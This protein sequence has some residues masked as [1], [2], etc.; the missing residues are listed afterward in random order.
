VSKKDYYE[1]LGVSRNAS[2]A[3]MKSAYRKL[4]G[5]YHPDVNKDAGSEAKFKEL[6]EA[7]SVLGDSQKKTQYDQFGH[8]GM[9]GY[10]SGGGGFGGFDMSG[11]SD[12][13]GD[14]FENFFSG[15]SR[16]RGRQG[17]P[18]P[19]NDLRYDLTITL[20]EAFHGVDKEI[21]ILHLISCSTCKGSGAKA[22]TKSTT[23][24]TCGG[25]GMVR[26]EQRTILGNFATTTTCPSCAGQGTIV[27]S[28][29]SQCQGHGVE[30]KQERVKVNIP[31]GVDNGSRLRVSG[32]GDAGLKGGHSGDLYIYLSVATHA[33]F[34][35]QRDDLFSTSHISFV[36]ATLGTEIEVP[37]IDGKIKLKIP[38]G[39]Q[40]HTSFRL[41][42]KGMPHLQ[43][44]G[45]G[46]LNILVEV[47]TPSGLTREQ[48]D[49]LSKFGEL[50]KEL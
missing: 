16:P 36:Q 50:R 44:R 46:S 41:R 34:K 35:R 3:E 14:M 18:T 27:T 12:G 20:E 40:S 24:S 47:I 49:L 15:S 30:R 32:A 23:C 43:S 9:E 22:G 48:R 42:E 11:F 19:G 4:A 39:T 10:G 33:T 31:A 45:F 1:I 38:A 17:G 2:A 21:N 25:H 28:P 7:Y 29:C 13:F 37:T 26:Q 6:Q 8:A 5:K